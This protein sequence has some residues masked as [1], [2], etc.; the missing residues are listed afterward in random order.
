M[1]NLAGLRLHIDDEDE[2]VVMFDSEEDQGS[3]EKMPPSN[4]KWDTVLILYRRSI[5]FE[6]IMYHDS[7]N[8]FLDHAPSY[9]SVHQLDPVLHVQW[10]VKS[11]Q[12][13]A[14]KA[15]MVHFFV[16]VSSIPLSDL[17]TILRSIKS[18]DFRGSW[19]RLSLSLPF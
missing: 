16:I 1:P 11:I 4:V 5:F 17:S 12:F 19:M 9:A 10:L 7:S 8:P 3:E 18:M 13:F 14:A 2:D 6:M 15:G